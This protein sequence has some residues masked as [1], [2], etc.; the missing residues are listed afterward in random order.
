MNNS[1][2]SPDDPMS[3]VT[4]A[5]GVVRHADFAMSSARRVDRRGGDSE[6]AAEFARLL[7]SNT[8]QLGEDAA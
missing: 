1:A 3:C 6:R 7:H 8:R 5:S 4:T 2:S